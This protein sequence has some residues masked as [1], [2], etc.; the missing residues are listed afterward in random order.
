MMNKF[1]DYTMITTQ[2]Q[3]QKEYEIFIQSERNTESVF[4]AKGIKLAIS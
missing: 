3:E 2:E 4:R 1:D